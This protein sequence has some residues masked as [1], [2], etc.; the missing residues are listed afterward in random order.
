VEVT[1]RMKGVLGRFREIARKLAKF[2]GLTDEE[3][4]SYYFRI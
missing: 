3:W 4:N 1:K 2:Q